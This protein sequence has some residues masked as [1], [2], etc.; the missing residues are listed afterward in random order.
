MLMERKI[1]GKLDQIERRCTDLR[2]ERIAGVPVEYCE[3]RE[4]F[5][6]E[7]AGPRLKWRPAPSATKWGGSWITAWFRGDVRLPKSCD[8]KR[9]FIRAKTGG[10]T[11]LIVDGQYRGVFDGWHPVAMMTGR[12]AAGR[13]YHLAFESY[14]GHIFPGAMPQDDPPRSKTCPRSWFRPMTPWLCSG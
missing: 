10:E 6:T 1:I 12:C 11:L 7:P 14:S 9:V 3:T 4:H 2:F 5:R 8:G 13:S